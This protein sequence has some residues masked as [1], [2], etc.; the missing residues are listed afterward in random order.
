MWSWGYGM[1][2]MG[3]FENRPTPQAIPNMTDFVE[4]RCR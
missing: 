4:S 1:L 3:N 2:G